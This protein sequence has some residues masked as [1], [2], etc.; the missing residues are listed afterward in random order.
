MRVHKINNVNKALE[1][2]QTYNVFKNK[3][4]IDFWDKNSY[5]IEFNK[6]HKQTNW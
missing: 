4:C 5:T 1:V 2:F 6:L 3:A